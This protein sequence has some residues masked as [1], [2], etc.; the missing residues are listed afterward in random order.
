MALHR[1]AAS[2]TNA[3]V[4]A[5]SA[6]GSCEVP[7]GRHADGTQYVNVLLGEHEHGG[8]RRIP[9]ERDARAQGNIDRGEIE[10]TVRAAGQAQVDD[11]C[12]GARRVGAVRAIRYERC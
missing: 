4:A 1:D 7:A 8:I 2:V 12:P 3:T 11:V 10:D 9:L 6:A 5:F